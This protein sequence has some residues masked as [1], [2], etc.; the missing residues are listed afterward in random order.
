MSL[1][2]AIDGTAAS[3]KGTL[4]DQLAE[5]YALRRVDAGLLYRE[6]AALVLVEYPLTKTTQLNEE[7]VEVAVNS[8]SLVGESEFDETYL[9]S[10]EINKVVAITA[11][12]PEARQRIKERQRQFAEDGGGVVMDGRNITSEVMAETADVKFFIDAAPDIRA[13]R[14]MRQLQDHDEGVTFCKTLDVLVSRDAMDRGRKESPLIQVPDAV[15][16]MTDRHSI[17]ETF[18]LA[19]EKCQ[20]ALEPQLRLVGNS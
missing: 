18:Q 17:H 13:Q 11:Q 8:A 4:A 16:I 19:L 14:R 5:H 12:I 10:P 15:C 2:I 20:E 3:G 1:N 6:L 7:L 9:R